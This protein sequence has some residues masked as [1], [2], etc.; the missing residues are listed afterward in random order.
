MHKDSE[1]KLDKIRKSLLPG[2]AEAIAAYL[3]ARDIVLDIAVEKQGFDPDAGF[4][5]MTALERIQEFN[6]LSVEQRNA[7]ID[8]K[9]MQ[10][11]LSY[12]EEIQKIQETLP[13]L[14]V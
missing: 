5:P 3:S 9:G 10:W 4:R 6:K 8:K 11:Y 13:E 12:A 2:E 14:G 7:I 1:R